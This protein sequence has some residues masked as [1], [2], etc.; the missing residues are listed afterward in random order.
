[1]TRAVV[2]GYASIDYPAVLNGYFKADHT[3]LIRERSSDVFPRPGG[4]HL[5][6]GR[7]LAEAGIDTSLV[8][9]IGDD[10]LGLVFRSR[11]SDDGINTDGIAVVSPGLTPVCFLIYQEDGSCCCC[12]D[13]GFMG[14]ETLTPRQADLIKGAELLCITVGPPDIGAQALEL[15]SDGAMIAWVAKNDPVSYPERLRTS[16]GQRADYIFCNIHE[17]EW[18]NAALSGREKPPPL[19][20]QTNGAANVKVEQGNEVYESPVKSLKFNDASGAGDTLA[21]GSLATMMNG[22][23]NKKSIAEAGIA[24]ASAL[25]KQRA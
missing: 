6:V 17:R 2:T 20:I 8:T 16:L 11:T 22:E 10:D 21:G 25:L 24:A 18:I 9:W 14:K 13:P 4:S 7:C 5:Y 19:I 12:F 23:I 15:A 1:M 3:V